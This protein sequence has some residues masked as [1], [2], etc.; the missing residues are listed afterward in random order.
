MLYLLKRACAL[1]LVLVPTF[2]SAAEPLDINSATAEQLAL[3][4]S[5]VGESKAE[6]IV[7]YRDA[8]GPFTSIDDLVKVKGIGS[9]LLDKNR[10]V[11]QV[12]TEAAPN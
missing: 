12:K 5:G 6:A 3:A 4:L 10:I 8:N 7:A 9:S 1:S 11:I 2:I